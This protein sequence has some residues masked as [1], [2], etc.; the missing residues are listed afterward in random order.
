MWSHGRSNQVVAILRCSQCIGMRLAYAEIYL[1]LG[2]L[3]RRLGND[4]KLYDTEYLVILS[5]FMTT[6]LFQ[7]QENI[8][9]DVM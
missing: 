4:L 9:K 8:V 5:L 7:H 6:L 1:T 3:F 2:Y